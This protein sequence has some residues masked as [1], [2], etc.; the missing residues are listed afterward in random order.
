MRR[1]LADIGQTQTSPT[2]IREDNQGAI[3]LASNPVFHARTKHIDVKFHYV[4]QEIQRKEIAL[5]Y[6]PTTDNIADMLTKPLSQ[7]KLSHF[8]KTALGD[9]RAAERGGV[10]EKR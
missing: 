3:K 6:C 8:R 7:V 2:T 4:R 10:L 1:I 5:E 9:G